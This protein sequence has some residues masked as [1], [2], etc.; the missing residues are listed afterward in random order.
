MTKTAATGAQFASLAAKLEVA[1]EQA[2]LAGDALARL[3]ARW[4]VES[5]AARM[6]PRRGWQRPGRT[7]RSLASWS[8]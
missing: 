6:A 3:L 8:R 7:P 4:K 5:E 1:R 2:T